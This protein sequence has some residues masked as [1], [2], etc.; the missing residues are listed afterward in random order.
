MAT[1]RQLMEEAVNQLQGHV[2]DARVD[3]QVLTASVF[4]QNRAWLIAHSDDEFPQTLKKQFEDI[5]KQRQTGKPVAYI[6]GQREFWSLPLKVTPDTLIPRPDTEILVAQALA[7]KLPDNAAILDFGTGTGAIAL[8][9]ASERAGWNIHAL[10]TSEPA[11]QIA[12]ENIQ[13]LNLTNIRCQQGDALTALG[14]RHFN[15]IISNPPYI[16]EGDAHLS[17]GDIRFEPAQALL[18]G[19]DGLDCIRY[20][21][22]ASRR[23]LLSAGL[24]LLEHGYRQGQ[25]VRGLFQLHGYADIKTVTDLAGHERMTQ[26]RYM[27]RRHTS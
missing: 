11:L 16:A 21:I 1:I 22:K 3:V 26:G 13:R 14:K 17:T 23:Y 15:A 7:A 25:A 5:I 2:E 27:Q 19:A 24:L 4:K 12:R 20:L 18:A 8:A 6:L 10:E 9:L